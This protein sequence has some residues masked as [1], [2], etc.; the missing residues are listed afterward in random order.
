[1]DGLSIAWAVVEHITKFIRARTLFATHYHE[2]TE[3]EGSL[4]GV[5]NYKITVKEMNQTVVFLRK[6]ARGGANKSFGV[7]VASLAGVPEEVTK[8]AKEILKSLE[9]KRLKVDE[10]PIV[11]QEQEESF[12]VS[13]VEK[14]V[15]NALADTDPSLLTPLQALT[16]LDSL[17][18]KLKSE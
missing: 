15:L 12:G 3:I 17:V 1:Y 9:K 16:F 5:K 13:A 8:R 11:L 6:I 2:L 18:N 14:D 10:A 7:E 4:D